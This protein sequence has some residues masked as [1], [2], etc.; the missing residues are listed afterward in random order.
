MLIIFHGISFV[1]WINVI[2]FTYFRNSY[3]KRVQAV[4]MP[5]LVFTNSLR[6]QSS[7]QL[8]SCEIIIIVRILSEKNFF[9]FFFAVKNNVVVRRP[10][11]IDLRNSETAETNKTAC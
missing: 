10:Y 8:S 1:K 11:L 7:S 2:F 6:K 4:F 3:C 5:M 9:E